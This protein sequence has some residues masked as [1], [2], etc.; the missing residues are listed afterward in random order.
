MLGVTALSGIWGSINLIFGCGIPCGLLKWSRC[1]LF[2]PLW[3]RSL[4]CAGD[5]SWQKLKVELEVMSVSRGLSRILGLLCRASDKVYG[6]SLLD[7]SNWASK[8]IIWDLA[9]L[10]PFGRELSHWCLELILKHSDWR[11]WNIYSDIQ[12]Q[13]PYYTY[14][15]HRSPSTSSIIE[16]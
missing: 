13:L 11:D 3:S 5:T 16:H 9:L 6:F 10:A 12:D 1:S 14:R 8:R 2:K 7:S 4:Q 15:N